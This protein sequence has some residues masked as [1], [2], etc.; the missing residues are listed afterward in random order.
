MGFVVDGLIIYAHEFNNTNNL[1]VV[2]MS[3]PNLP[4]RSEIINDGTGVAK[5]MDQICSTVISEG[6][7]DDLG[8]IRYASTGGTHLD[9]NTENTLYALLGIKLKSAYIGAS[10]KLLNTA[11][12]L[13]TASHRLEWVLLLN[14]TVA[15]TFTYS[16]ISLSALQ[17]AKG[18]TANT[19]TGGYELAGGFVE[20]G[21]VASGGAGSLDRGIN[22]AVR[23]GSLIDGTV[24]SIVL[25]VRPIGGTTNADVEGSITWRELS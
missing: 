1:S 22:N 15:D 11:I 19:V 8:V 17:V 12:Q 9:A 6:G 20:S 14:P 3:T 18:A 10:I 16:D 4:L 23:L 5:S 24:D 2:Y 7:S 21:S 13:Q 25:A